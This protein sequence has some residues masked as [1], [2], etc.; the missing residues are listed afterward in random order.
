MAPDSRE[1][2]GRAFPSADEALA[3]LRTCAAGRAQAS[4]LPLCAALARNEKMTTARDLYLF[5]ARRMHPAVPGGSG[6]DWARLMAAAEALRSVGVTGLDAE[7]G[8]CANCG[9]QIHRCGHGWRHIG[10][11]HECKRQPAP[12]VAEPAPIPESLPDLPAKEDG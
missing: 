10:G 11:Q 8:V 1:P 4:G 3:W 5:L 6:H 2:L 9:E 12:L 7:V